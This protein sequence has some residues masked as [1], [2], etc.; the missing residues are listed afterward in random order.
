MM[1][2]QGFKTAAATAVLVAAWALAGC[3]VSARPAYVGD[4]VMLA[5]PPPHSEVIG[6][7]PA[8][9]YFWIGGYWGWEGGRHV[10]RAGHWE[11]RRA[12]Y[13][14]VPNRW[15]AVRG[16]GWRLAEGHWAR[17]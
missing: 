5:P 14:W 11:P 4:T 12:G 17:R 2:I 8:P 6:V 13:H 7:A 1:R 10:W 16:G 15:V 9:G 3:V